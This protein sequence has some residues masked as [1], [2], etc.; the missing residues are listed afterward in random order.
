MP[1]MWVVHNDT[2]LDLID[3]QFVSIGWDELGSL[4]LPLDRED[5]KARLAAVYPEK[6]PGAIPGDAAVLAK[7]AEGMQ[8]GD[9]II[10]P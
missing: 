1:T 9:Y 4:Q 6:K 2:D 10:S 5:L 8:A 3:G 7:F